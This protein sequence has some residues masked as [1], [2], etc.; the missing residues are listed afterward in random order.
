[1]KSINKIKN[2]MAS[3]AGTPVTTD[4]ENFQTP[5][6]PK[7]HADN[8]KKRENNRITVGSIS[9]FIF[10]AIKMIFLMF[11]GA[12]MLIVVSHFAPELREQLPDLYKIADIMLVWLE[13]I[14]ERALQVIELVF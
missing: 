7:K 11:S 2:F 5:Q 13:W 1:M 4:L 8:G 10:K 3:K 9:R 14:S 12:I 6:M